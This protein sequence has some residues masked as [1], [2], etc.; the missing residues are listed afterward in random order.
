MTLLIMCHVLL[1]TLI[2]Q[3]V[4]IAQSYILTLSD[5]RCGQLHCRDSSDFILPV[6]GSVSILGRSA[7]VGGGVVRC[8]YID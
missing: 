4:Q 5:V 8:R 3:P 2:E 7:F 6:D 1:S